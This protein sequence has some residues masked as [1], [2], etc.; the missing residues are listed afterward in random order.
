LIVAVRISLAGCRTIGPKFSFSSH[1]DFSRREITISIISRTLPL[2][3]QFDLQKKQTKLE[4][5]K[6][7][8]GM[9]KLGPVHRGGA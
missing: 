4:E 5:K 9:T 8:Q 1:I 6:E 2:Q 7:E 3:L